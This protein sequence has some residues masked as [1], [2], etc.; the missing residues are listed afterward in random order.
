MKPGETLAQIRQISCLGLPG[1]IAVPAMLE[2]LDGLAPSANFSFVWTDRNAAIANV[3]ARYLDVAALDVLLHHADR[4]EK[5]FS[6]EM[7]ARSPLRTGFIDRFQASTD[8]QSTVA[9]NEI[10]RPHGMGQ[11]CD[12]ILRDA[13]G[14]RG[15]A[16]IG[17]GLSEAPFSK[18]ERHCILALRSWLLHALDGPPMLPEDGGEG[19]GP[20]EEAVLLCD[21]DGRAVHMGAN[22]ARLL[23]YAGNGRIA[24]G[25][26]IAGLG[27]R[28]P[29]TVRRVCLNLAAILKGDASE[30][31]QQ[32][33]RTPWGDFHFRAH[34]LQ[35]GSDSAAS[36]GLLVVVIRRETPLPLR[37]LRRAAELPLTPRQR[38]VAVAIALGKSARDIQSELDLGAGTYRR[39][40]EDIHGRLAVSSRAE[41]VAVMTAPP[42]ARLS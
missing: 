13:T 9:Y 19:E 21:L 41:L 23:S 15:V 5:E 40:V 38:E 22:A 2:L 29:D 7:Q 35:S 33:L 25:A 31:P 12:L 28:M 6:F 36:E 34:A 4:L 39:H 10:L 14:P 24:P 11:V 18:S 20:V 17:R 30:A 32:T 37:L 26:V 8:F 1:E 27:D 3:S 42:R 16:M